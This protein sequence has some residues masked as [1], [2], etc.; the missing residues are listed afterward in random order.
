MSRLLIAQRFLDLLHGHPSVQGVECFDAWPGDKHVRAQMIW[1]SEFDGTLS[2]PVGTAGRK[3]YDDSWEFSVLTRAAG[4]PSA[5]AT[6]SR[7]MELCAAIHD[8]VADDPTLGDFG[9]VVEVTHTEERQSPLLD[10]PGGGLVAFSES[11]IAV[12]SRLT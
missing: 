8:V 4:L 9:P 7:Q 5:G 11:V 1:L 2:I 3:H 6:R 10:A 12:H